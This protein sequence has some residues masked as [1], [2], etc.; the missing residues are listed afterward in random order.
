[1][2]YQ[3]YTNNKYNINYSNFNNISTTFVT[4]YIY[5]SLSVATLLKE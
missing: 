1:M 2:H 5:M 4:T 3:I